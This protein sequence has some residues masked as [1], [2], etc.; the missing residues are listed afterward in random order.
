MKTIHGI[1]FDLAFSSCSF[2][3]HTKAVS[4][5]NA[6]SMDWLLSITT[7][8]LHY[9]LFGDNSSN[10]TTTATTKTK[11]TTDKKTNQTNKCSAYGMPNK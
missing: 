2:Q 4:K 6:K 5:S 8:Q 3:S 9:T 11:T 1:L 7:I 10:S